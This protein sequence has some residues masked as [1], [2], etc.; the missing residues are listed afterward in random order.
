VFA[1]SDDEFLPGAF[2][3]FDR[4]LRPDDELVYFLAEAVQEVDGSPS[5]RAEPFNEVVLAY[6]S[7][8]STETLRQLCLRHVVPWAKVYS[9]AFVE[10]RGLRF[11]PVRIGEDVPFNVLAA[12]QA[13]RLRVEAVP[14]YRIY[15]RSGSLT[16]DK[17]SKA[18]MERCFI[19]YSLA[20]RLAA[21]GVRQ[22]WPATGYM[23]LSLKYGPRVALRVWWLAIRS[24]MKVDWFR[25]FDLRRRYRLIVNKRRESQELRKLKR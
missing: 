6:A 16:T 25:I 21:L 17:S 8:P 20:Q 1:D 12:V 3:T 24:P 22:G 9:R 13:D 14:V 5:V 11:D 10:S 23:L 2:D 7:S 18:F 4:L 19:E 15:R